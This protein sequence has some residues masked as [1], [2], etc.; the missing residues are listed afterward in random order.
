MKKIFLPLLSATAI[1]L[2]SFYAAT[3]WSVIPEKAAV[4]FVLPEDGTK[5]TFSGLKATILFDPK[6]PEEAK[7]TASIDASTVNTGN[8]KRD[9]HLRSSDFFDVAKYPEIKFTSDSIRKEGKGFIVTG[10][11]AMKDSVKTISIPFTF[12]K[13]KKEAVFSGSFTI[14]GGDYGV[15]KKSLT[16]KDKVTITLEVAAVR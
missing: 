2:V 3:N 11:L 13:K 9:N 16:G 10:L 12:K 15:M 7:I 6:H 8:E 14:F 4:K 5:G 1:T